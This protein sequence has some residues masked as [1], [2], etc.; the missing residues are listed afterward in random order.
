MT[1]RKG[2]LV[3]RLQDDSSASGREAA[4]APASTQAK[5]AAAKTAGAKRGAD[6]AFEA[7]ELVEAFF[8]DDSSWYEA[9]VLKNLGDAQYSIAWIEDNEEAEVG[10]GYIRKKIADVDPATPFQV[11]E[12]VRALYAEEE[13]WYEG[14]IQRDNGDGTFTVMWD[15]DGEEYTIRPEDGMRKIAPRFEITTLHKGQKITGEVKS[16][17]QYGAFID[18]GA[19]T[20]G[21][22]HRS[23]IKFVQRPPDAPL[24]DPGDRVEALFDEDEEWYPATVDKVNKDG[25]FTVIW[26]EDGD[27]PAKVRPKSMRLDGER[28]PFKAGQQ[29]DLWVAKLMPDEN[30]LSLSMY[31]GGDAPP[32]D[33]SAFMGADPLE[34]QTGTITNV[35]KFGFL[36]SVK[37]PAGATT[38]GLVHCT[39]IRD[40]YVNDVADEGEVGQKVQVR[41]TDVD[42][43]RG[44][45]S[46]S[47]KEP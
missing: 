44:R 2:D 31:E 26:D 46:L 17:Q 12:A 41:I 35:L 14:I 3:A 28:W 45:V 15:E 39:K 7:G 38:K 16:I 22:L 5:R 30:K 23:H 43:H 11:G 1:G 25:T 19:V 27:E 24:Y 13:T 40:G 9:K 21:L 47:M 37:S 34:W 4:A 29:M 42:M 32:E 8:D 33:M 10:P 20:E 6:S 36:V 18:I